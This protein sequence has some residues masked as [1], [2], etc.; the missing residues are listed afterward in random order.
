MQGAGA[1][2]RRL[3]SNFKLITSRHLPKATYEL[4]GVTSAGGI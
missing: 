3:L 1:L 4:P 2:D